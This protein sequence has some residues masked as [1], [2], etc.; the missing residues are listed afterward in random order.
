MSGDFGL[1]FIEANTPFV[2]PEP[3]PKKRP[4]R[5]ASKAGPS[6][7]APSPPISLDDS[8]NEDKEPTPVKAKGK[9][10]AVP[11]DEWRPVEAAMRRVNA[12]EAQLYQLRTDTKRL[13]VQQDTI[14][15]ELGAISKDLSRIPEPTES[16]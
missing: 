6:K 3:A 12:L 4:I 13:E 15:A 14:I 1:C 11:K 9:A 8:E 5:T 7:R 16:E 10:K 2:A